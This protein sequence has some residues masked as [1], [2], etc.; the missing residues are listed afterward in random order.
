M[1]TY[2]KLNL[3]LINSIDLVFNSLEM[4]EK[5]IQTESY[6]KMYYSV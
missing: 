5:L 1:S 3:L 4:Q 2:G 6:Y